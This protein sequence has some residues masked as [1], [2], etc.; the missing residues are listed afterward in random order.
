MSDLLFTIRKLDL[1]ERNKLPALLHEA[2]SISLEDI[3]ARS[4]REIRALFK[5][6]QRVILI[7]PPSHPF[8]MLLILIARALHGTPYSLHHAG[9]HKI[10]NSLLYKGLLHAASATFSNLFHTLV[11]IIEL[12][13][14]SCRQSPVKTLRSTR[15][16][17]FF[18]P[19]LALGAL[20]GGA[21]THILG[22]VKAFQA[23]GY[24]P[25]YV[26]NTV[27]PELADLSYLGLDAPFYIGLGRD[28]NRLRFSRY[29]A[30]MFNTISQIPAFIYKRNM[31]Y[32]YSSIAFAQKNKIPLI[33]EYNG[34][35]VWAQ[36]HWGRTPTYLWLA[37]AIEDLNLK[38][39]DVILTISNAAKQELLKRGVPAKKI[40][41]H[42]NG[43]DPKVFQDSDLTQN[44]RAS[45]L[46]NCNFSEET[47]LITFVGT[48]NHWHGTEVFAQ[49]L[50]QLDKENALGNT[51]A[52]FIGAGP[53]FAKVQTL[54]GPL[55]AKKRV[56]MTGLIPRAQVREYLYSSDICVSPQLD[57]T[58]GT[59]FFGSPTKIF[60]YMAM[61][62]PVVT[63]PVGDIAQLFETGKTAWFVPPGNVT[64]L[65]NALKY[66]SENPDIRHNLGRAGQELVLKQYT[67]EAQIEG[68]LEHMYKVIFKK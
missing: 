7:G 56:V 17:I 47:T 48:F 58:D 38:M 65:A 62:K 13:W 40:V 68:L 60:E 1:T 16:M 6:T 26:G 54:L 12:V 2:E 53:L 11:G 32:D 35:E 15:N 22:V 55:I 52:L 66:L 34:S 4:L 63:T 25:T 24:Q 29:T 67:W 27:P 31:L 33:L 36:I 10:A 61:G 50:L 3:R 45:I 23:K 43:V 44:T 9:I 42:P 28:L 8:H 30:S 41:C 49:A 5:R 18:K 37:K 51:C 39:A 57:N 20:H 64:A 46:R 21:H 59:P 19:G 14:L